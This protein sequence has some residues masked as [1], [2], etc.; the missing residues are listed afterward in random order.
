MHSTT[1]V[2]ERSLFPYFNPYFP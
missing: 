1:S 2:T